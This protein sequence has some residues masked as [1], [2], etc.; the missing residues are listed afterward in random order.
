MIARAHVQSIFDL[1]KM[2]ND[3]GKDLRKLMKGIEE[4]RLGLQTL[5][6][7]VEH[8]DLFLIFLVTERLDL[9]TRQQCEIASPGRSLQ[10]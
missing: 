6:L 8:Y 9:E 10:T 3:N 1:P 7:P 4:H 5:G 2:R